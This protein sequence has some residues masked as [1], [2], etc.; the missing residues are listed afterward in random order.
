MLQIKPESLVDPLDAAFEERRAAFERRRQTSAKGLVNTPDVSIERSLELTP[1]VRRSQGAT[2]SPAGDCLKLVDVALESA[3]G[4]PRVW[5][6]STIWS[7]V[8][9]AL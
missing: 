1:L 9:S 3:P 2:S 6:Y 5:P 8:G 7:V 4:S